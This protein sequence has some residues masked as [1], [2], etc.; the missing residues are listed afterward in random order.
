RDRLARLPDQ[1]PLLLFPA[2]P[3]ERPAPP[4]LVTAELDLHEPA[5]ELDQGI[6]GLG[7]A[8]AAVV[9]D[10]DGSGPVVVLRDHSL[11]VGGLDGVVLDVDGQPLGL[12]PDG[13]TFGDGPALEDAV[14][15]EAQ[16]VVKP[17]GGM[18]LDDEEAPRPRPAAPEGLGGPIRIALA[19]VGLEAWR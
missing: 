17:P 10:D 19:P 15:L 9:P 3:G 4:E 5:L 16:V 13:R 1:E 14:H 7:R 8:V 11:E 12:R 2:H 6:L 18:L